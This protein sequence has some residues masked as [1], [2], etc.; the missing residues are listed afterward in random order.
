MGGLGGLGR[1]GG[2]G[3]ARKNGKTGKVGRAGRF[4]KLGDYYYLC[5]IILY[6]R[7]YGRFSKYVGRRYKTQ[8]HN[9]QHNG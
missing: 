4:G 8:I 7:K 1:Q 5:G 2:L 6:Y 3:K 9:S